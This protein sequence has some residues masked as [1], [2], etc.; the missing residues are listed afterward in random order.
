[1]DQEL[2]YIIPVN[3]VEQSISF[4]REMLKRINI[5]NLRKLI[6]SPRDKFNF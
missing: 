3:I 2:T 6:A 4:Y 1:M 5:E